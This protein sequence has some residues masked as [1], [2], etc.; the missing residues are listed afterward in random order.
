MRKVLFLSVMFTF[1]GLGLNAQ[2]IEDV[3]AP[4]PSKAKM[5]FGEGE[6]DVTLDYGVIEK[7]AD[8][9]RLVSFKNDGIEPLV[10][11]NAR[12]SCGCTVPV[13]PKDPILPGQTSNIEVRYDTNRIGKFTKTVTI[14]TNEGKEHYIRV[15]G[16]V[17]EKKAD[18]AVP[19]SAPNV[20][21]G[22]K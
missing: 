1:L 2:A 21:K 3:A 19:A 12:G 18:E 16:E 7:G 8:P 13:W 11:N 6:S 4:P 5:I 15:Q 10:I 9:L 20:I 22:G 17:F 14:T